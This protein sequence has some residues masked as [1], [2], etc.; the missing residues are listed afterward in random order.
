MKAEDPNFREAP[1]SVWDR[2]GDTWREV[3][4]GVYRLVDPG[5]DDDTL[6]EYPLAELAQ[7][8]GPLR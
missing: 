4:P 7:R 5:W 8:W 1:R 6:P 3:R 2:E